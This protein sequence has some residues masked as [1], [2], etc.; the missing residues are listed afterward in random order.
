M[1][2]NVMFLFAAYP[3]TGRP[4]RFCHCHVLELQWHDV[5]RW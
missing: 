3:G 4:Y 1:P 2:M 5:F